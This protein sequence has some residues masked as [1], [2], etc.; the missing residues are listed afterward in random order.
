MDKA[1]SFGLRTAVQA[2]Q[3]T[4]D[5][6]NFAFNK[7]NSDVDQSTSEEPTQQVSLLSLSSSQENVKSDKITIAKI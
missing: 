2:A 1:W 4:S 6:V 3:R 7:R 5:A